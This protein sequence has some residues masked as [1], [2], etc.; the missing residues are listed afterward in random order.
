M[1]YSRAD[2][3]VTT[4]TV[5]HDPSPVISHSSSLSE[6]RATEACSAGI[7]ISPPSDGGQP[8]KASPAPPNNGAKD[9]AD[10][11]TLLLGDDL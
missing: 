9:H 7:T 4:Q 8:L 3:R 5:P 2:T 1:Q 11:S 10:E 6:G